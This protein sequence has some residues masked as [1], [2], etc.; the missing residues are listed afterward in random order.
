[1]NSATSPSASSF[2]AIQS[3]VAAA[4][5]EDPALDVA[6]EAAEEFGL[7]IPDA[8]TGEFLRFVA[9]QAMGGSALAGHTPT[10]IVMSPAC[11]VL[12]VHLFR[13]FQKASEA[14]PASAV[15]A[16]HLTCIE[17]EIQHQQLAKTAFK[18]AGVLNNAY[19]FLPSHPLDVISRL[20]SNSYDIAVAE[21]AVEDIAATAKATLPT[22]RPGG[23]LIILD[24]L[25][26]GTIG[27]EECT[28][29]RTLL[30]READ[31][32]ISEMENV[33]VARLPLGAGATIITK[34]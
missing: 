6:T 4:A 30:A 25:L 7:L 24:T 11:G 33:T 34:H 31:A 23:V 28:D 19:R 3:Y 20:A 17:P 10:G 32:A 9:A 27:D 15:A 8:M 16:A 26:D 13:G 18:A 14:S 1:M 5:P 2:S 12:G 29:R 22:L 21:C